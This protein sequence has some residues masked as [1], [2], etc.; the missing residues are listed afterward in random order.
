MLNQI[1][2]FRFQK[3]SDLI[4]SNTLFGFN[5]FYICNSI[6]YENSVFECIAE[7]DEMHRFTSYCQC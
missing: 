3:H 6:S 7:V 1:S 5:R 4:V 2:N